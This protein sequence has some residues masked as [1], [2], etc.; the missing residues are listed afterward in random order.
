MTASI[1]AGVYPPI[2]IENRNCYR[3]YAISQTCLPPL[4]GRL[5]KT[6]KLGI[7]GLPNVGKSTLFNALTG[8]GA[9]AASYPFSTVTPNI[10]I[11]Q[12]PDSR[13]DWLS[14]LYSPEK[15]TPASIEFVDIAGLAKGAS[16]GE[17]LGNRFLSHIRQTDAL[18]HV[19]RCF[20]NTDL[21]GDESADA[22]RDVEILNLDLVISDIEVVERRLDKAKKN[23]KGDKRYLGEAEL[24]EKLLAHLS[25]GK[26]ARFFDF[27]EE[28]LHLLSDGGL[29]SL[30]PVIYAANLDEKGYADKESNRAYLDLRKLAEQENARVLPI[31]A[32]LEQDIVVLDPEEKQL[33][34]DDL[35]IPETGLSLLIRCSYELL[36]LISY[37]TAGKPEVRAWT[38]ARGTKAPKA[39]GKI[40]S[41]LERGF[42]R[43]E[44]VAFEDLKLAGNMASAKEKGLV[45]SEGKE[46]VMKDGDVV[47]FRF[48]V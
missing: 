2:D 13:L 6:M 44:V 23:A 35:G 14:A 31:C 43:A 5:E 20:D 4:R 12:V 8:S 38:I 1:W 39:A 30:K 36:G 7:V 29:L 42:I 3:L 18:V 27:S 10:G 32:R 9:E 24:F 40:H 19:V 22:L 25:E 17:G 11:V 46:Y 33:F 34:L 41:D 48:N 21:Y 37:L 16:R 45:R 15:I 26:A 28:E 47:L